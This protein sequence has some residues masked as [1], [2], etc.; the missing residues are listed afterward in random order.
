[1]GSRSESGLGLLA[2]WVVEWHRSADEVRGLAG[3]II[4]FVMS[5]Y[6]Q[7]RA[8]RSACCKGVAEAFSPAARLVPLGRVDESRM[9]RAQ[10]RSLGLAQQVWSVDLSQGLVRVL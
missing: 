5:K 1:M 9:R 10:Y 2:A 6:V 8:V 7:D 3:V 4:S